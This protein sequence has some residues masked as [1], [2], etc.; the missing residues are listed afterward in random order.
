MRLKKLRKA[1]NI[2]QQKLAFVLGASQNTISQYERKIREADYE[3]LIKIA[4]YFEVSIDYLL[5]RTDN[6][7][8]LKD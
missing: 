4:D 2:S 1:T 8:F 5:E 6:P 3:M 7:T